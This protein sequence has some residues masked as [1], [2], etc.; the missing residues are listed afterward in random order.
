MPHFSLKK[1][2]DHSIIFEGN[3][4]SLKDCLEHAVERNI[5]LSHVNLKN[6]N[7]T[8]ANID[9]ADMPYADLS[10]TNLTGANLSE[11]DISNA[12]FHNCGLY[13]TCLS[14]SNL[15]NSDFRGASFGAT[16]INGANLRG[17]VFS[18][19]SACDLDFQHAADMFFCQYITT[20]GDHY[21]MSNPPIVI[22]G[23]LNVPIIIFDDIIKIG[24]KT[25]SKTNMPQIS[26]ILSFYT[27]K[28]IT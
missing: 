7:L 3:Y 14:E 17:C 22:K 1:H 8:N 28:I 19:L 21:N 27:H 15:K 11:A 9:N 26:H 13:N 4:A 25:L 12:L 24:S 2:T 10:G 18:T 5:S 23:L 16:L 6:H 20:E